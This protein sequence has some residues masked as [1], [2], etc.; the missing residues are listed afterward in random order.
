[1]GDKKVMFKSAMDVVFVG[2]VARMFSRDAVEAT[3]FTFNTEITCHVP[4][5]MSAM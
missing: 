3:P 5:F 4:V 2:I 1:M